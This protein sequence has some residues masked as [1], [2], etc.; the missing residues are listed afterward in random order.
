MGPITANLGAHSGETRQGCLALP[1]D[2]IGRVGAKI[3]RLIWQPLFACFAVEKISGLSFHTSCQS[4][5]TFRLASS[6]YAFQFFGSRGS[7]AQ[8]YSMF[9]FRSVAFCPGLG[10]S[11]LIIYHVHYYHHLRL[12]TP[13]RVCTPHLSHPHFSEP[14]GQALNTLSYNH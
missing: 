11:L 2:Y 7:P 14:A 10:L 12:V 8:T 4:K 6:L 1:T 9:K 5:G 13:V 3:A